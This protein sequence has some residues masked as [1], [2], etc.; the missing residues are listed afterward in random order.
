MLYERAELPDGVHQAALEKLLA[1]GYVVCPRAGDAPG[2]ATLSGSSVT[3]GCTMFVIYWWICHVSLCKAT[4]QPAFA[5]MHTSGVSQGDL[6]A[7]LVVLL[8]RYEGIPAL[9]IGVQCTGP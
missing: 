6:G 8:W 1:T 9:K 7:C 2:L 3:W 5:H 4:Q